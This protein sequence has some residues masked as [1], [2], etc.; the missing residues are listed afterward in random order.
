[1][2]V[3][4]PTVVPVWGARTSPVV[5]GASLGV[6]GASPD[7]ILDGLGSNLEGSGTLGGDIWSP[8]GFIFHRFLT[9]MGLLVAQALDVQK[10]RFLL[11]F[12]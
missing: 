4:G 3:L 5:L 1:M 11:C 9:N 2:D 6:P 12:S 7:W 10:P 8:R